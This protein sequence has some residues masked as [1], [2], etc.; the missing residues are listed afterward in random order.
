MRASTYICTNIDEIEKAEKE[1]EKLNLPNPTTPTPKYEE[2]I[3]WFHLD[4]VVRAYVRSMDGKSVASLM[5]SDGTI[6]DIKM[7][8]EVE[9]K[10]DL[11]F[12]NTL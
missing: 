1:N 5:F 4:D 8:S 12:R 2:S 10:L 3:G 11:L 6:M 7:T 9:Q